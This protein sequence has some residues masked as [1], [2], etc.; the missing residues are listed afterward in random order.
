[1]KQ[2][3]R[4]GIFG[5][6]FNPVHNAH[7]NLAAAF[8]KKLKLDKLLIIPTAIPP[9]KV[10]DNTVDADHRLNMCRLAFEAVKKCEVCDIEIKRQGI[11]YTADTLT[12]L[13]AIYPDSEFFLIM[14]A[15]MFMSFDTWHE[16]E[17]IISMAALCAVPRNEDDVS[18][19][20]E[21][22]KEYRARGAVTVILDMKKSDISSTMVRKLVFDDGSFS[23]YVDPNVEKYI[24]ANYLYM[25]K[26][27]VN[28]ERFDKV[29]KARMGEKR[30]IHSINVASEAQRLAKKYGADVAKAKLAGV[31]HDI[32][33]ETPSQEQY[34]IIKKCGIEL[35]YVE[36]STPKLWHAIAGAGFARDIVGIDDEDVYNAIRYHTSGRA[37][38]S[39]LEKCVFIA[40]FTGAERDYDG[41][42]EMRALAEKSLEDAMAFGLSFS[43][44]DLA[45]RRMAIDPNSIACYNEVVFLL[46]KGKKYI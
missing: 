7:T 46:G 6:S 20:S 3:K 26:G 23:K 11:S 14:G 10:C 13:K 18:A 38:M 12:Q 40:D 41:V 33:K 37:N 9:H 2:A 24:Y 4:I 22:E 21:K 16:P 45:K 17:K 30:Y 43:I 29:L 15:D 32:T 1:M 25:N 28:Y 27:T 31:L 39:V 34:E 42:N 19:L 35:D 44:S 5:G 36:S 8:V